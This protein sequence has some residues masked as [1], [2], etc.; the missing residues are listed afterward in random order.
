MSSFGTVLVR[1][2]LKEI[3]QILFEIALPVEL[4]CFYVALC[5]KCPIFSGVRT[6]RVVAL[7]IFATVR[8]GAPILEVVYPGRSLARYIRPE[9]L[10]LIVANIHIVS[11]NHNCFQNNFLERLR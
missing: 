10:I 4:R 9:I 6:E 5:T 11:A 7:E 8:A 3:F 2:V 1:I